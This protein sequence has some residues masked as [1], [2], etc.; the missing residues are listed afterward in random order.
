[1]LL[2][3]SLTN[4]IMRGEAVAVGVGV[5]RAL[6][7]AA[8]QT[9]AAQRVAGQRLRE[10]AGVLLLPEGAGGH[11]V[12]LR[13]TLQRRGGEGGRYGTKERSA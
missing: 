2:L 4:I 11:W 8:A 1:M 6:L 12:H 13:V 3:R 5:A 7:P 9:W 10:T